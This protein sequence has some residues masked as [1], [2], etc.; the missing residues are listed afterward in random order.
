MATSSSAH[1]PRKRKK[2]LSPL[3]AN[4]SNGLILTDAKTITQRPAFPLVAFFWPA[5]RPTSQ[6][7]VLPLI[8]MA[9]GLFRWTTGFWGYSGFQ[10][11][12]MHGDFE[13]QRHWMEITTHLPISQWYFYDLE[14]WGLDYPPLTAYHSWL[15]GKIGSMINPSWFALHSSRGYEE[16]LLKV[17]MRATVLVSEYLVYVPAAVIFNRRFSR[18]GGINAWEAS[19]ALVAILM[20]PATILIDHAHF[21]YNT[22]MLGFVLASMSSMLAGRLLWG[23][24]F[25][26]AGLCFKQMALYYAPAI[27]AYLLGQC[28]L[29]KPNLRRFIAI[30]FVTLVT[31]ALVLLPIVAGAFLGTN[32]NAEST[33]SEKAPQPPP[34]LSSLSLHLDPTALYYPPLLQLAQSIHRIFPFGRGLF[35]DKVANVWCALHTF[36]KLHA[37][38]TPLLQRLSLSATLVA[39][40]PACMT[41]SLFPRKDLLPWALASTAWGFFLCSFQVHEKSVLLPL[42]PM[43][44]LLG[45][46]GG[47]GSELR[48]WIGWAN[49]LGVWTLFPLLKRDVLRAPYWV[50]SLLWAYL[51][52]LPPAS[53]GLYTAKRDGGGGLSWLVRFLHLT[54]YAAMAV[55]HVLEAFLEPPEAKP[56]LWVVVNVVVGAAGFGFCFLWCTWQLIW[57]S[58]MMEDYFRVRL[59]LGGGKQKTL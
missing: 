13:A 34:L 2:A 14:Y 53:L 52:G 32:H 19:I 51:L 46:E 58:G 10:T 59:R 28:L 21:Q 44:V 55:W 50:L 49:L 45:G 39:I 36:H 9:V 33:I 20:Q 27:F 30:A 16:Q 25:F 18:L 48:A 8:L 4:S 11:R 54:F 31:F 22:V 47:L 38:P 15:L 3:S 56:D 57:R 6:W 7:L 42:L 29:P 12:P 40:L 41:I 37:Y 1:T 24:V 23:C 35:E 17:Y 5:R 26:V 43:T